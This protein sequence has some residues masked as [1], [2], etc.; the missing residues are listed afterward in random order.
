M[1]KM[2]PASE[3]RGVSSHGEG[4]CSFLYRLLN[5]ERLLP[6][7]YLYTLYTL[8]T[9][10]LRY[11]NFEYANYTIF[12]IKIITDYYCINKDYSNSNFYRAT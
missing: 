10:L 9:I 3:D 4:S 2:L 5:N 7:T 8:I 11:L 6:Y 12:N 1:L